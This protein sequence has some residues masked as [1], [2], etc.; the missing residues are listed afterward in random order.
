[1]NDELQVGEVLSADGR[2][3][4][5]TQFL[6]RGGS[7]TA[8]LA[9]CKY[10]GF[11]TKC[12]LK[13]SRSDEPAFSDEVLLNAQPHYLLTAQTQHNIRRIAHLTNQTPPV[14]NT[15]EVNGKGFIEVAAYNGN[16]LDQLP[17]LTLPQYM[18]IC[19]AIAK[20]AHYYHEGGYLCLDLKPENIF[21]LQ[22]APDDTITQLVEFIDFTSVSPTGE[23]DLNPHSYTRAWAAPEQMNPY[24][25]GK[26]GVTA[27]IYTLGEIVFYLL[28]GRHSAD[29]EH[30]G[31][32]KYP[33]DEVKREY[34]KYTERPD[35]QTLF[36]KL[37]RGTIRSAVSNR[38][39]DVSDVAKLLN[40]LCN[41][42]NRKDYVIPK[43]PAVS[44]HFVGRD[45][46]MKTIAEHLNRNPVLYVTGIGGIG[47]STLIRNFMH[48]MKTEYDVLIYL[49]Y[50]GDFVHTFCDDMQ[51]QISTVSHLSS[52]GIDEYFDRKLSYLRNICAEKRVLFVLDNFS[53]RVTKDLSRVIDCGYDTVIVTRNQPPKNSFACIE[54]GAIA[55]AA[56][57]FRLIALNLERTLNREERIAFAEIIEKVQG[58]TLVIE[59]IARQI[60]A[61]RLDTETALSLIREHGFSRF[62]DAKIGNYKDGEEVYDTLSA[63]IS[64]L[65]DAS[66]VSDTARLTL[67]ILALLNVSGLETSLVQKFFPD[68]QLDTV[69]ELSA[70]GWLYDDNRIRLHPVI[71]ETVR[72]WE[73]SADDVTVMEYHQKMID[74][75]VGMANDLQIKAIIDEAD[76]FRKKHPRHIIT[77]MYYDMLAWYYDVLTGGAYDPVNEH[78][79]E[80]LRNELDAMDTAIAEMEQSSDPRRKKYLTKYYISL[81]S[82]LIHSHTD[83]FDEAAALLIK[84]SEMIEENSENH[85]YYCMVLADYYSLAEPD[86]DETRRL[87][88]QAEC[89]A[90]QVFPTELEIIDIIHIPTANCYFYHNDFQS[91]ADKLE[92]AVEICKGYPDMLPYIDKHAE[93]LNCL[94]DV[95]AASEDYAKCRELIAE[96]DRINEAYREQ[97]VFREVSPAIREKAG[98]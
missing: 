27:D 92:E 8:Y 77:A 22:N 15:F 9:E 26:I 23:Y 4:T 6:G 70:E 63:I 45:A 2:E 33:F 38:F 74:I 85:C 64:A 43:L 80:L 88:E 25:A 62:S 65:F 10:D 16:T 93:L 12:I 53:G 97:G 37:F 48:R 51:L 95:Y 42:L 1:M 86:I 21:I 41:E 46:E 68:I 13:Q 90:R 75:Y 5:I 59:L 47:K 84:V 19:L 83:F 32:S 54:I 52:E 49:E 44:P 69:S 34:R 66:A 76:L 40:T 3:Y 55:D 98:L 35:I 29:Q 67:K 18:E 71:A 14:N 89:I 17:D 60:A 73:W 36:T 58:H 87:T 11:I 30:R 20:T 39:Q 72:N 96:I 24:S 82:V 94:L 91:A 56:E 7:Y 79:A 28:F 61:G 78:E 81:A 57:L 50:D 31:F